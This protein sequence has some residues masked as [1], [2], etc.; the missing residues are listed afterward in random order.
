MVQ[1][2]RPESVT[3]KT[4]KVNRIICSINWTIRW[5]RVSNTSTG[6]RRTMRSFMIQ[7]S[8]R[9]SEVSR[10]KSKCQPFFECLIHLFKQLGHQEPH[11][12]TR[13]QHARIGSKR[14]WIVYRPITTTSCRKQQSIHTTGVAE[15]A[16]SRRRR[17]TVL[18]IR[19][20]WHHAIEL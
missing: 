5:I 18:W 20:P 19:E 3:N 15:W 11:L 7:E 1:A 9:P 4:H 10:D 13:T 17:G 6:S 8:S 14:Q 2:P 16:P 12:W